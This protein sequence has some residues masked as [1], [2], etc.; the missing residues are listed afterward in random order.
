MVITEQS[1]KHMNLSPGIRYFRDESGDMSWDGVRLTSADQWRPI[2]TEI[3]SFG[4]DD[5]AYWFRFTQ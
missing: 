2:E 4:Y 3:P 5:A 1:L